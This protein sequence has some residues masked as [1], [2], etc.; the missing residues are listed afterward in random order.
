MTTCADISIVIVNYNTLSLLRDCLTSLMASEAKLCEIIV[1]DNASADGSADMVRSDF[2]AVVVLQN[3]HNAGFPKANNWGM[4]MAKNKFILM[5]NSDT[6]VRPEALNRMLSF[7]D[8]H[9]EVGGV[10]C[11]LF[12]ADGS[13]QASI[14]KRP[15]P[16]LLM[17]RL[18]GFSRLV[19]GDRARRWLGRYFGFLLGRT[20][21][22]YLAPYVTRE[23]PIEIENTSGA[24]LL[25]RREVL[26][27][28]GMLDEQIFMYFE[29]MDYCM[30]IRQAGW[31]LYYLPQAEVVH[32]VGASS[33]GRMRGYSLQ[34]YRA[35]FYFYRK[36]FSF[37]I[38]LAARA[39]VLATSTLRWLGNWI[40]GAF[41]Q[42]AVYRQNR[43]DLKQVILVCFD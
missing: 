30:R 12:N 34:S 18:L 17:F 3:D 7:L 27:T 43:S 32:L 14:S 10:T 15:G 24:C 1:V 2:P 16:V 28:V 40:A 29:D 4:R 42:N 26:D 9:P 25:L 36:H 6:L 19:S 39:M 23:A 8:S 21:R 37:P 20:V 13:I 22:S 35:L 33:G 41:S 5:L 31:K 11:R 38:L